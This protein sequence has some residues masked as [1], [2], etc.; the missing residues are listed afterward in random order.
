[1]LT[2]DL[3]KKFAFVTIVYIYV[4]FLDL[5]KIK[6]NMINIYSESQIMSELSM[7]LILHLIIHFLCPLLLLLLLLFLLF[8]IPRYFHQIPHNNIPLLINIISTDHFFHILIIFILAISLIILTNIQ[9][10]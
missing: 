3:L 4:L 7:R 9:R 5:F 1:M 10:D 6:Q 8:I 2:K